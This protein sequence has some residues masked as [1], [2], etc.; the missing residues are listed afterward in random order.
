MRL[1]GLAAGALWDGLAVH[2]GGLLRGQPAARRR[3]R[4]AERIA[5]RATGTLGALKGVFAKLGQFA[6]T[7][8]DLLPAAA[9]DALATLRDR[10]PPLS[11]ARVR[12]VIEAE[13]GAPV[14]ELF[15]EFDDTPLGA[16]S[17]AQVHRAVLPSGDPVAVKVQYPWLEAS[18]P[19][20]LRIARAL[21]RIAARLF[22]SDSGDAERLF[23][24]F[25]AGLRDE[26]D[27]ER[28]ARIAGEIAGNLADDPRIVVPEVFPTHS[29]RRVLTMRY[30]AAVGLNDAAGL[31]RLGVVP[32]ELLEI[33]AH[34][35]ATQIFVDG[36][37][38][39]DPHPGNLFAIDEPGAAAAPRV[40]FVDFGLSRRLDPT[41]RRELRRGL[42]ALMQRDLPAFLEGM[43]RMQMIV[44]GAEDGVRRA[45][46]EMFDRIASRGGALSMAGEQ[47][48][49][50]KDEAKQLLQ[51]TPGLRL[52]NDL[53]L[54]AK[55]LSYLF[56]L[57]AE[58]DPRVDMM[59][60]CAPY[61]LR[62][63]AQKEEP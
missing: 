36:L 58:L 16:A 19:A 25:A 31:T 29:S 39:A 56:A 4:L 9:T 26:L 44:P 7:R 24:E 47:V 49:S 13:L 62:F 35:Y 6:A 14:A 52:P 48:L 3:D 61:A 22:G 20:D 63:L 5:L 21:I 32:R 12:R 18:L 40:L 45:L 42:Y 51:D 27:F 33:L 53:L 41:L 59:R 50:L 57:G 34:A 55:T 1:A 11:A 23:D 28:E 2:A 54:Y 15:A 30:Y 37:F 60:L 43:Q 8:L 38:H 10:V 46:E 17:I